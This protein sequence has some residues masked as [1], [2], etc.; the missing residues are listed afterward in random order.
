MVANVY[1]WKEKH[2]LRLNLQS[3]FNIC[4]VCVRAHVGKIIKVPKLKSKHKFMETYVYER[5]EGV[6][7]SQILE[8]KCERHYFRH[9]DA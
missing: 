8:I 6:N 7:K 5:G 4:Q 3:I 1:T 2:K 9:N